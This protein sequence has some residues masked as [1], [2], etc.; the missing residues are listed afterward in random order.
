MTR[1]GQQQEDRTGEGEGE[2]AKKGR[3]GVVV[4]DTAGRD[5]RVRVYIARAQSN[6]CIGQVSVRSARVK[7]AVVCERREQ[8][9]GEGVEEA[10]RQR[11][12][13]GVMGNFTGPYMRFQAEDCGAGALRKVAEVRLASLACCT[14]GSS[15]AESRLPV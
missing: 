13:I 9:R 3:D 8:V 15:A 5:A 10:T 12:T 1:R 11:H 4:Q 7:E 2:G 6:N 14:I